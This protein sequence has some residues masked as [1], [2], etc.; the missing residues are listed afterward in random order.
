MSKSVG[1]K[2]HRAANLLAHPAALP[3]GSLRSS[4]APLPFA[5][6]RRFRVP[7]ASVRRCLR[8]RFGSR[9]RKNALRDDFLSEP[10][11]AAVFRGNPPAL[12][13]VIHGF[14]GDKSGQDPGIMGD[15][16]AGDR[17]SDSRGPESGRFERF[18]IAVDHD[19]IRR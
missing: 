16:A 17:Q 1:H 6:V 7:S 19:K 15:A 12:L 14:P 5:S 4:A 11:K 8:L 3:P 10:K 18:D 2:N 9:K 13:A